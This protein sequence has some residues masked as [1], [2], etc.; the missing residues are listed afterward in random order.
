MTNLDLIEKS[1]YLNQCLTLAERD[2][3]HID[4]KPTVKHL[5]S[6]ISKNEAKLKKRGII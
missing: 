6:Q 3:L 5:K 2:F 1:R 4:L